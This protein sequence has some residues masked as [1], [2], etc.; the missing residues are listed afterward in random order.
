ME[1]FLLLI[2]VIIF[3]I[4][5][6]IKNI[7]TD[8]LSNIEFELHELRK[9]LERIAT[10]KTTITTSE[11]EM[12]NQEVVVEKPKPKKV[13]ADDYWKTNFKVVDEQPVSVEQKEDTKETEPITETAFVQP[14][15][16]PTIQVKQPIPAEPASSF[17]E[18][19]PDLEKF[20]GENLISKIG[21]AILVIAIGVFVKY[22]IDN[23]WI[24]EIGRVSIGIVCGGILVGIAHYLRN[25]Y[26]AFSSVLVGGSLAIF[27]FTITLAYHQFQLFSQTTAFIIMIV[28]TAFAVLLSILYNRQEPAIIALLGGFGAPF[29]VSNG[30]GN[31]ISLF[32]YLTILNAGLL[33]IAYNKAWRLLNQL[34][35]ICTTLIF[36][37]W[38]FT[39]DSSNTI[40]HQKGL[41]FASIFYLLFFIINIA[42]N[43]KENKKFLASDFSILLANTAV[44]FGVGIWCIEHLGAND[45]KGF[46]SAA[47]AIFNLV[48]SYFLLRKKSVDTNILYLLIGITL[49]FVSLT[50]PLQLHGNYITL[51]WASEAVVIFWLYKKAGFKILQLATIIVWLAMLVSLLMDIYNV[52]NFSSLYIPIVLNRGFITIIYA[53]ISSYLLYKLR[54]GVE[55]TIIP[56]SVFSYTALLLFFSAGA[57]EIVFQ[58]SHYYPDLFISVLY[59]YLYVFTFVFGL[60]FISKKLEH[61]IISNKQIIALNSISI[62]LFLISLPIVYAVQTKMLEQLIYREHFIV[63][64][65]TAIVFVVLLYSTIKAINVEEQNNL[66]KSAILLT[67]GVSILFLSVELHFLIRSIF[68]NANTNL[69]TLERTYITAILPILWGLC[70]FALMWLGMKNKQRF[71]RIV[72][73]SLF[74]ITLIK[75]FVFDIRNIPVAGKIAAFFSLGVLLLI[76]SFMYQRLKKIIIQ[77]EE[78]STN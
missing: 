47:L 68:F 3:F 26:K 25:S 35:F 75:L 12:P 9:Q 50:A 30:S 8:K 62:L 55:K 66:S 34:A 21:I 29:M 61:P 7:L 16:Q 60:Q 56:I 24:G 54:K 10:T 6:N 74:S 13:S 69:A 11:V 67:C 64:W 5:L 1:F 70:S 36:A 65:L 33:I 39:I 27:Y 14:N 45:Y 41:L 20:I 53:A 59:F 42:N 22:A 2:A 4:V 32:T 77:D 48:A 46:F 58:F 49:T 19:N 18:R 72:S 63:H 38:L 73:L 23:N 44:Y 31:Y 28:I 40:A 71:L 15:I 57:I 17:F 78:K 51:F 76:V 37:G 43:I 52:Y